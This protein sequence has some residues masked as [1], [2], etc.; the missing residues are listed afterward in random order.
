VLDSILFN[1]LLDLNKN[2]GNWKNER[3]PLKTIFLTFFLASSKV[4]NKNIKKSLL[5]FL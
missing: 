4:I 1:K 3:K 5:N 2:P